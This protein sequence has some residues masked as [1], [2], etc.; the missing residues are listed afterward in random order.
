MAA[1]GIRGKDAN[2]AAVP[3]AHGGTENRTAE[4]ASSGNRIDRALR[5]EKLLESIENTGFFN[6][7]V[8][9]FSYGKENGFRNK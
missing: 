9:L 7:F 2:A 4:G 3:L 6:V 8:V 1:L 5:Q